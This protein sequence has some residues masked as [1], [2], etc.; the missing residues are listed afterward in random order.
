MRFIDSIP[1]VNIKVLNNGNVQLENN[2]MS[3]SYVVDIHPIH[4]R[5]IAEKIG[6]V[7]EVLASEADQLRAERGRTAELVRD[8]ERYKRVLVL[9]RDRAEQLH[10]NIYALSQ[11]GRKDMCIEVAQS[12][13]HH[14]RRDCGLCACCT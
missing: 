10:Q 13:T 5:H 9:I 8:M 7:R 1:H 6:L 14:T 4:L 12:P 2:S 11:L 3:E